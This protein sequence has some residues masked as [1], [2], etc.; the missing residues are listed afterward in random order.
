MRISLEG[1]QI[2]DAIHRRGS[3]AGA[4]QELFRVPST[5]TYGVQKLEQD[6]GLALFHRNGH[7]SRLTPAGEE[8]LKE[9][10]LILQA[11]ANLEARLKDVSRPNA[12]SVRIA[13]DGVLPC[14]PMLELA[15]EFY[16][17]P[18]YAYADL[19]IAHEPIPNGWDA[20][21]AQH[22]DLVVGASGNGLPEDSRH[23]RQSIGKLDVVAVAGG[24][25]PLAAQRGPI[26]HHILRAHK[27]ALL[28]GSSTEQPLRATRLA[29]QS[30]IALPDMPTLRAALAMGLAISLV[31]RALV[32]CE[33]EAGTLVELRLEPPA[34]RSELYLAWEDGPKGEAFEWWL[35]R[36]ARPALIEEWLSASERSLQVLEPRSCHNANRDRTSSVA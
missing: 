15:R 3:F 7:R 17:D 21:V 34:P 9:G 23:R 29:R 11:A 6:L 31:P 26:A 28:A 14:G 32:A 35:A 12:A 13:L 24:R 16:A 33:L 20:P 10:R 2:I 27:V 8:L 4:A 36:L 19:R 1:L 18:Q 22:A 5:I 25:H 30:Y